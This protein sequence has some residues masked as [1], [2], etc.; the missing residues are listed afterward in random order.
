MIFAEECIRLGI[1]FTAAVPFRGQENRW[2]DDT[3]NKYHRLLKRA[4]EVV[5]VDE[6]PKYA[7]DNYGAK[8]YL[9]NKWMVDRAGLVIA[10]WDGSEGGTANCVKEAV[11]RELKLVGVDPKRR[12]VGPI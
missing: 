8:L 9:R 12:K 2:P 3:Q 7:A 11:K 1:P 6:D 10:V 5:Y 4:S